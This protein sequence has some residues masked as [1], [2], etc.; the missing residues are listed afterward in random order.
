MRTTN[1]ADVSEAPWSRC[2]WSGRLVSVDGCPSHDFTA[3]DVARLVIYA[4]T[5][6]DWSGEAA[7]IAQLRD[8][9]FIG[10]ESSWDATGSGFCHDA[11][12]GDADIL[13]ATSI[14]ALWSHFSE[15]GKELIGDMPE[16][17]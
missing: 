7:G 12:G 3:S 11:Y 2:E 15:R 10:W 17:A 14:A 8:G 6:R 13:F 4:D 16:F 9:R 5:G 1:I